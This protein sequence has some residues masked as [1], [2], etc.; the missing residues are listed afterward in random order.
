M[1]TVAKITDYW[2]SCNISEM[3]VKITQHVFIQTSGSRDVSTYSDAR[4]HVSSYVL[5]KADLLQLFSIGCHFVE[6]IYDVKWPR[7]LVPYPLSTSE[8]LTLHQPPYACTMQALDYRYEHLTI[9][10]CGAVCGKLVL[11]RS[12]R[13]SIFFHKFF[14]PIVTTCRSWEDIARQSCVMVRRW[15]F[16]ATFLHPVFSASRVQH[17]SD[18]HLKFALRPHHVCKYGRHSLCDGWY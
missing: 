11:S 7:P 12:E 13:S 14:F 8:Y 16:L 15:R 6:H 5:P 4:T 9:H 2:T 1:C 18:L 10:I 17:V 3:T